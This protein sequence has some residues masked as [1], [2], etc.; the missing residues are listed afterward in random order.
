MRTSLSLSLSFAIIYMQ[1]TPTLPDIHAFL[2]LC[3]F[4]Y[5]YLPAT[6]DLDVQSTTPR[7]YALHKT[8]LELKKTQCDAIKDLQGK[9]PG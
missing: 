9:S 1:G 5:P 6:W 8:L 3:A 2:P 4:T 7:P